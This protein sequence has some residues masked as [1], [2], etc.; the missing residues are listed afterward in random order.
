LL[1]AQNVVEPLHGVTLVKVIDNVCELS[2]DITD[3][4]VVA[5]SKVVVDTY[6]HLIL[7]DADAHA[8]MLVVFGSDQLDMLEDFHLDL[9]VVER[10]FLS[11]T[12]SLF[13]SKEPSWACGSKERQGTTRIQNT[14]TTKVAERHSSQI[15]SFH[16]F[17]DCDSDFC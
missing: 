11:L 5:R 9:C 10:D 3:G 16:Q 2:L 12:L 15:A 14:I 4:A 17:P 8:K 6:K 7:V 13:F 1:L